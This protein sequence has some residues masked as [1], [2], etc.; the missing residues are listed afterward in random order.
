MIDWLNSETTAIGGLIQNGI[1]VLAIAFV[2]MVFWRS[3]AF[4][5]TIG[6]LLLAGVVIWGVR[7]IDWF[8]RQIGNE[9]N[10]AGAPAVAVVQADST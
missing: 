1:S 10:K 6:A 3:K 7:N 9:T 5:P 4:A 2:G 8:E